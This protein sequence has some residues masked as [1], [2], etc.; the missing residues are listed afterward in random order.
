[1]VNPLNT[2]SNKKN[3]LTTFLIIL[4]F[5]FGFLQVIN[6]SPMNQILTDMNLFND[7]NG[8][9]IKIAATIGSDWEIARGNDNIAII[10]KPNETQEGDLLIF[11]TT[12]DGIGSSIIDPIGWTE[13]LPENS[14]EGQTTASW[15]KIAGSSESLNY[16]V[17]WLGSSEYYVAGI[18][19]VIGYDKTNPIQA[20]ATKIG[21]GNI[22]NPSVTTTQND[23]LIIGFHGLDREDEGDVYGF[24]LD[25]GPTVLYTATA[26]GGNSGCSVGMYY[27]IQANQGSSGNR[28]W[29][30]EG[31]EEWYA[32]TVAINSVVYGIN[33]ISPTENEDFGVVAP[34]FTVE[35]TVPDLDTMWYTMDGGLTNYTFT[36]NETI[37]QVAWDALSDGIINIEFYTNNT[38]GDIYFK[39]VNVNKDSTVPV[40]SIVSPVENET[41]GIS[42]PS[43]IVEITDPNLDTMWYSIYNNT[44]QSLNITFTGNGT[45]DPAVWGAL[46]DGT[47][48]IRFY[49]NDSLGNINFEEIDVIKDLNAIIINITS[50]AVNE[51]YGVIAPNF[52]VEITGPNINT[53][54]YTVDGGINN[55]IFTKNGTINQVAWNALPD[56]IVIIKFYANNTLGNKYFTQV[57]VIKNS[58]APIIDIVSPIENEKFGVNPPSF[59]VEITDPNLDTMWYS[60]YNNTYQSL[61]F[62]FTGNGTIDP[63]EWSALYDGTYSIRFYANNSLGNINFEEVDVIKDIYAIIIN[64]TSPTVN[65]IYGVIAPNFTVEIIGTNINT[66]WYTVDLGINNYTF[67]E[68]GTI[69]QVAWSALSDGIVIIKFYANNTLGNIYF[70]QVNVIKDSSAP[71][72]NIISPIANEEFGVNPPGFIV[73]ISDPNLDTMWYSIYNNTYQSLNVTFIGNGTIDPAEWG[74]LSNGNY[75]LRFYANNSLGNINFKEVN[76]TKDIYAIF[77]DI[78]NPIENEVFGVNSPGFIVE[79]TS[80]FLNMT[81]YTLDGGQN[82][83][84][85][86]INE[87]INEAAWDALSDGVVTIRFY[88]NN[89]VGDIKFE[90]VNV[91]KDSSAPIINIISPTIN[92]KFG[93]NPPGF[94]VEITDPN[95]NTMWYSIY[96]NT[97]QSLNVTFIGNG[98][99]DPAEWGAL[100]NGNYTLRFYANNSLGNINFKEVN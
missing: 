69:N 31:N 76:I 60:I 3:K 100:S 16:N 36:E 32:A 85:F 95:L 50:P 4:S 18:I 59:I 94:I 57:H 52:T 66:T 15:Y 35:V 99:I 1:M 93:V 78:I 81:W 61:N 23:T 68:N 40:I 87:T 46:Y 39:Q 43:F 19:R 37:N 27:E 24:S 67:T 91:I 29:G 12:I 55:Y 6:F 88:A 13:L 20:S 58:S 41:F 38:F 26:G 5:I 71:I 45:I 10:S 7:E 83:Y 54:W 77:I 8:N 62:T 97:Y 42:P 80:A 96:N 75:T 70:K 90:Q 89:S 86:T 53:T 84:T 63:T 22:T 28:T 64:I 72:I 65:E 44:Y 48:S 74:A 2:K 21:T 17:S 14:S 11:H 92:E 9:N 47:Y 34:N 25:P 82:N 56:G 79:I 49:A 30:I 73:E 98:T 51:I 33:I